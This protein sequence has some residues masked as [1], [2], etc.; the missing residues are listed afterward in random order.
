MVRRSQAYRLVSNVHA[1]SF[2]FQIPI[3][4]LTLSSF[5]CHFRNSPARPDLLLWYDIHAHGIRGEKRLLQYNSVSS[6]SDLLSDLDSEESSSVNDD[7]DEEKLLDV[8]MSEDESADEKQKLDSLSDEKGDSKSPQLID[9]LTE[10]SRRIVA[11]RVCSGERI[12]T[13]A[14]HALLS[15]SRCIACLAHSSRGAPLARLCPRLFG[16]VRRSNRV[17]HEV[18]RNKASSRS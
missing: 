3:D 12:C 9:G 13:D 11:G 15:H 16:L 2:T 5:L 10:V 18:P 14:L 7:N 6:S 17:C 1:G 8:D 4:V